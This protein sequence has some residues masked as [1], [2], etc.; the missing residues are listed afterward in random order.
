MRLATRHVVAVAIVA[1]TTLAAFA[2]GN[3]PSTSAPAAPDP[4]REAHIHGAPPPPPAPLR[5]GERFLEVGLTQAFKPSPPSGG[6]DEYRCFLIDPHIATPTFL[7]GSQ[8]LPQNNDIVHHAIVYRVDPADVAQAKALDDHDPGDGWT[9]FGGTGVR[10]SAISGLGD[11]TGGSWI[12]AWAPG[13]SE[14]LFTANVGY[15]LAPGSQL[16]LQIHYNL[17]ETN[18]KPGPK[19]GRASCRERV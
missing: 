19:I 12:G 6:T 3:A 9:C 7:T 17:L 13:A 14:T 11:L 10:S 8:F 16:V 5:D 2:C 18:G 4:V 15:P 1:V